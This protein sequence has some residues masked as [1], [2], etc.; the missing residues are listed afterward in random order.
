MV[1]LHHEHYDLVVKVIEPVE[2]LSQGLIIVLE[3]RT[4]SGNGFFHVGQERFH[5]QSQQ[6]FIFTG[7]FHGQEEELGEPG[8]SLCFS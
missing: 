8:K 6:D 1:A 3:I 5:C 4:G 2:K 7:V